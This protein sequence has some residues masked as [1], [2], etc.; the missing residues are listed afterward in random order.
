MIIVKLFYCCTFK[1]YWCKL[2]E[3]GDCAETCRSKLIIQ[4]T[5]FVI[6]FTMD[7]MNNMKV[8]FNSIPTDA[9]T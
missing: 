4:Y 7:R 9:H 1:E 3:G 6:Q 2:S 5:E 8:L